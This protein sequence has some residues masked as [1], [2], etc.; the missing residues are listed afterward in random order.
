M[1]SYQDSYCN[2]RDW[3]CFICG[4]YTAQKNRRHVTAVLKDAYSIYFGVNEGIPSAC[5]PEI[6]CST[7]QITLLSWYKGGELSFK[8]SS[9]MRWF[10]IQEHNPNDCYFCAN[11]EYGRT[12]KIYTEIKYTMTST[13]I[14]KVQRDEGLP[15]PPPPINYPPELDA[16]TSEP[17]P[18]TSAHSEYRP[19]GYVEQSPKLIS[20]SFLSDLSPDLELTKAKSEIL[21]SRLRLIPSRYVGA[22]FLRFLLSFLVRLSLLSGS[23]ELKASNSVSDVSEIH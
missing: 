13:V 16:G 8:Y 12:A 14:D 17:V 7:C 19:P 10:S 6:I 22:G 23:V 20:Q 21:G 3:F 18:S 15:P 5:T 2:H 9:P 1:S 4:R 11:F